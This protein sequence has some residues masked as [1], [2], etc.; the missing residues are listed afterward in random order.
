MLTGGS[1]WMIAT[2]STC[3]TSVT[4]AAAS[5]PAPN[6]HEPPGWDSPGRRPERSVAPVAASGPLPSVWVR[7]RLSTRPGSSRSSSRRSPEVPTSRR[8]AHCCGSRSIPRTTH[9]RALPP[10]P[11]RTPRPIRRRP[12]PLPAPVGRR[13]PPADAHEIHRPELSHRS[14]RGCRA[15]RRRRHHRRAGGFTPVRVRS[16]LGSAP[17]PSTPGRPDRPE[18]SE[19]HRDAV[20]VVVVDMGRRRGRHRPSLLRPQRR[21]GHRPRGA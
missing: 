1:R 11:P 5:R 18:L 16:G 14:D 12:S 19:S 8:A 4:R 15:R 17:G 7:C 13:A 9:R 21:P 10:V 2:G 6:P 20:R 3:R